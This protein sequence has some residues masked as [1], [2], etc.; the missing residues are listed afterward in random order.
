MTSFE[1]GQNCGDFSDED[2]EEGSCR[3]TSFVELGIP[4]SL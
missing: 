4:F 2:I 3:F 1:D